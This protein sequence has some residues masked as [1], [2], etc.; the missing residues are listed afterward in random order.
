M[1]WT[2]KV[3]SASSR[4]DMARRRSPR[5]TCG[6][7]RGGSRRAAPRPRPGAPPGR[8]LPAVLAPRVEG[9]GR[10]APGAEEGAEVAV[11]PRPV[12]RHAAVVLGVDLLAG[13]LERGGLARLARLLVAH[14]QLLEQVLLPGSCLVL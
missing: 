10:A 2:M 13:D 6:P 11:D 7:R 5:R 12:A 8:G 9:G 3:V 4:I 1:P 14:A